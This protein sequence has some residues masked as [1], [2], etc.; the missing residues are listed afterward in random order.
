VYK[1]HMEVHG[2]RRTGQKTRIGL[3]SLA[4][5]EEGMRLFSPVLS[6]TQDAFGCWGIGA[7]TFTGPSS[8]PS[9]CATCGWVWTRSC[10]DCVNGWDRDRLNH[11]PSFWFQKDN[12]KCRYGML[13]RCLPCC[14]VRL[15]W[16]GVSCHFAS[17]SGGWLPRRSTEKWIRNRWDTR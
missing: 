6:W 14:G 11:L 1:V 4:R 8:W 16:L 17:T 15:G 5:C 9:L 3:P 10:C 2:R 12:P 13:Q 7:R